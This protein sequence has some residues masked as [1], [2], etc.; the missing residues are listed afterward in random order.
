MY[1]A[2]RQFAGL[3]DQEDSEKP[4][5][6]FKD[7]L[8]SPSETATIELAPSSSGAVQYRPR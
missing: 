7:V 6:V 2:Y 5:R 1:E 3:R 4:R 8:I